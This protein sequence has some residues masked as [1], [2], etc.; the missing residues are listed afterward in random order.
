MRNCPFNYNGGSSSL[1][2]AWSD[3]DVPVCNLFSGGGGIWSNL[4]SRDIIVNDSCQPLLEFQEIVY[5]SSELAFSAILRDVYALTSG[6]DSRLNYERLRDS[7][8]ESRDPIVFAALLS[9]SNNN[10]IRFNSLGDFNNTW[11][12]RKFNRLSEAKLASFRKRIIGKKISFIPG[13]YLSIELSDRFVIA[14][15]PSNLSDVE[16]CRLR[17]KLA[18]S[19]HLILDTVPHAHGLPAR[20]K[21]YHDRSKRYVYKI[22]GT[23]T[24]ADKKLSPVPLF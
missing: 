12:K 21:L 6:V 22:S 17:Q 4:K 24:T 9:C 1:A 23:G 13:D 11:G 15:P 20:Q 18:A 14:C 16:L 5:R 2:G 8:N 19:P 7:F 10:N 3:I